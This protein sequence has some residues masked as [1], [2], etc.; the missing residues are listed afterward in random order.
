M[1]SATDLRLEHGLLTCPF[2]HV[3]WMATAGRY[4]YTGHVF[5]PPPRGAFQGSGCGGL[6]STAHVSKSSVFWVGLSSSP[7]SIFE[8]CCC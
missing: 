1:D 7:V 3:Q 6:V 5:R 2:A 4:S 8:T